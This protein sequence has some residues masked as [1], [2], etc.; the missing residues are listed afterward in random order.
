MRLGRL[1]VRADSER[2]SDLQ[3][4]PGVAVI[5][6]IGMALLSGLSG[7]VLAPEGAA[8]EQAK[9]DAFSPNAASGGSAY[10]E[11]KAADVMKRIAAPMVGGI[12][13]SFILELLIYPAIY[14]IWKGWSEI[15]RPPS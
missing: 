11:W 6:T 9:L 15:R 4:A 5:V 2:T 12:V 14:V 10:F 8:E 3:R 1:G 7:C 13:T